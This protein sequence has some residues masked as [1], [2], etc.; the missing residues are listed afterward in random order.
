MKDACSSEQL[1][2]LW[3]WLSQASFAMSKAR[4]KELNKFGLTEVQTRVL[5]ILKFLNHKQHHQ[6]SGYKKWH[7]F[8]I[9]SIVPAQKDEVLAA[10]LRY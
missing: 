5:L 6:S 8:A 3:I 2:E 7:L 4:Q 10:K 9:F 1:F